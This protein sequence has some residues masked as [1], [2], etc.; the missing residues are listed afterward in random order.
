MFHAFESVAGR[1]F[2]REVS[3][4][5]V[6]DLNMKLVVDDFNGKPDLAAARVAK[7]IVEGLFCGE[8]KVV[9]KVVS[10]FDVADVGIGIDPAAEAAVAAQFAGDAAKK[11]DEGFEI[12]VFRVERPDG[13]RKPVDELTSQGVDLLKR[14]TRIFV[15][16]LHGGM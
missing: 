1:I 15:G 2:G 12:V 7:G 13:F 14:F 6:A 3:G 16:C 9:T 5:I 4:T 10:D 11:S 8:K